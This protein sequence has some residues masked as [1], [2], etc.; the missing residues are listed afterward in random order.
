VRPPNDLLNDDRTPEAVV[1]VVQM[2]VE[3]AGAACV[4]VARQ[5]RLSRGDEVNLI[6]LRTVRMVWMWIGV[7]FVNPRVVVDE[8][9]TGSRWYGQRS[10]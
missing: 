2:I 8:R 5:L 4:Q 7:H 9:H 1:R 6:D 10:W 3:A